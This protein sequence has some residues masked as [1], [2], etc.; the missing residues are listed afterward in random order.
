MHTY[1]QNILY[2][3]IYFNKIKIEKNQENGPY[4]F[5]KDDLKKTEVDEKVLNVNDLQAIN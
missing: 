5:S 4:I 1:D 2:E 3:K